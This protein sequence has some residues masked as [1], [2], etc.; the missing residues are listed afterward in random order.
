MH[1]RLAER[2]ERNALLEQPVIPCADAITPV[3]HT[4]NM[5][6]ERCLLVNERMPSANCVFTSHKWEHCGWLKQALSL[7]CDSLNL[8]SS[9]SSEFSIK[10]GSRRNAGSPFT[11]GGSEADLHA[12][13]TLL[14]QCKSQDVPSLSATSAFSLHAELKFCTVL[15]E[16]ML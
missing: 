11:S 4:F 16:I 2:K 13:T 3:C 14:I 6:W 8:A 12:F 5:W 9:L 10:T 7:D 1:P 15:K